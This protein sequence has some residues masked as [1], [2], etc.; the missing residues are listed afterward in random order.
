MKLYN[1]KN[2]AIRSIKPLASS[3]CLVGLAGA[4]L[5]VA[6]NEKQEPIT[7]LKNES[8]HTIEKD[9]DIQTEQEIITNDPVLQHFNLDY[10]IAH[11]DEDIERIEEER[12]QEYINNLEVAYETGYDELNDIEVNNEAFE[13]TYNNTTYDLTEEELY[14]VAA[15]IEAESSN[16]PHDPLAGAS[17][18]ANRCESE[19]WNR[20]VESFG[21]DGSNPADQVIAPGQYNVY[22][23]G[24]YIPYLNGNVSD[25]V[26]NACIAVFNYGIRTH[27][28]CSFRGRNCVAYSDNQ[29]VEGGNRYGGEEIERSSMYISTDAKLL[30]RTM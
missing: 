16:N 25:D 22:A 24:S 18:V 19:S 3:L 12:M 29:V 17:S 23:S 26:L 14:L 2:L 15:V 13:L 5:T 11:A 7:I 4:I 27:N 10:M 30:E 6:D 21:L 28:F 9:V 20:Y 8:H 1:V